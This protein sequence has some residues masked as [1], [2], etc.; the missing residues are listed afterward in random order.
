[1]RV[2]LLPHQKTALSKLDSGS[3]LKGGVGTG[4]SITALAYYFLKECGGDNNFSH[5]VFP[6]DLIKYAIHGHWNLLTATSRGVLDFISN[7]FSSKI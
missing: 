7:R 6:K 3:I 2:E 5:M 1:M 4:K